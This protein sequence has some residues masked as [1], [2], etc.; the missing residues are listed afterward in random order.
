VTPTC[1]ETSP[2]TD[3]T[4]SPS[5]ADSIRRRARARA[6]QYQQQPTSLCTSCWRIRVH[7]YRAVFQR[8]LG[9]TSRKFDQTMNN[10]GSYGGS[11]SPHREK[12][13]I[14]TSGT[15]PRVVAW[16]WCREPSRMA[17]LDEIKTVFFLPALGLIKEETK[18]LIDWDWGKGKC[19]V[20]GSSLIRLTQPERILDYCPSL[21]PA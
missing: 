14:R 7:A 5:A 11:L 12:I 6:E 18:R 8:Y 16:Y 13:R 20:R 19:R 9:N 3:D 2:S 1:E 21:P 4:C 17:V 15:R 10:G